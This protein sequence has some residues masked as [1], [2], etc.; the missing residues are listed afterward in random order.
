MPMTPLLNKLA[1]S[2][3]MLS[4]IGIFYKLL[5]VDSNYRKLALVFQHFTCK[6]LL[7]IR[8]RPIYQ[9][10]FGFYRYI[11]I[12]QNGRFYRPQQMLTKHCY[13]PHASRQL[14][15]ESATKQAKTVILHQ[16]YQVRF[17]KHAYKMNHR[18]QETAMAAEIKA[19][20]GS[21]AMHKSLSRL[22]YCAQVLCMNKL[23]L[24]FNGEVFAA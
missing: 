8:D 20:S 12:G 13:I 5:A 19:S 7:T 1:Q 15:H 10:I 23:P 11:G 4:K 16:R 21:F 22:R 2:W 6:F 17:H 3:C 14:A 24:Y 9:S 18:T